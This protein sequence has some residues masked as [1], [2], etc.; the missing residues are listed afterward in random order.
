MTTIGVLACRLCGG[1]GEGGGG[2]GGGRANRPTT[3]GFYLDNHDAVRYPSHWRRFR[4][5]SRARWPWPCG[6]LR[7]P[8]VPSQ[9]AAAATTPAH[10]YAPQHAYQQPPLA[11]LLAQP[12]GRAPRPA[13]SNP[14][15]PSRHIPPVPLAS[16]L[17]SSLYR[18]LGSLSLLLLTCLASCLAPPGSTPAK[19]LT[20][21]LLTWVRQ[22][23][24]R[25][26]R[27]SPHFTTS[28]GS[29]YYLL[30]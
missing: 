12:A 5:G 16:I 13:F 30:A 10:R 4:H 2:W 17:P 11:H 14:P 28:I 21:V 27:R 19:P 6:T 26:R 20:P 22:V 7:C 25:G 9:P 3:R 24:L 8:C 15:T 1:R 18:L 29:F 23:I